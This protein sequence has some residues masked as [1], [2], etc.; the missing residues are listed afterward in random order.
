MYAGVAALTLAL[1]IGANV[2]IFTVLNGMLLR[3]LAFPDGDRIVEVR[4]H[5]PGLNMANIEGSP[6]LIL[7]YRDASRTLTRMAGYDQRRVN[8]TGSGAPERVRA[9]AVT[10]EIFDVLATRPALGRPFLESDAQEHSPPVA[11]LTHGLWQSR[12]GADPA[13]VGRT[14]QLDGKA[15][16]VIG[17][18]PRDFVFP[19]P[20]TRLLGSTAGHTGHRVRQLL[21]V[22][23]VAMALV[24]LVGSGLM[25]KSMARLCSID[26]GF[27]V[28]G[29]LTSSVSLGAQNDRR[30]PVQFYLPR[31]GRG[32]KHAR[33]H[34][35][36]CRERSSPRGEWIYGSKLR[37]SF[38]AEA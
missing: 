33:C 16:E 17:V 5:A 13:I 14:M 36:G 29:L 30:R 10:P 26:P 11:I 9:V 1:G 2:A 18:M 38:A 24:F 19:D 15:A 21:I 25:L 20:E 34:R 3:P 4:H 28:E 22:A 31:A 37:D 32:S 6:G 7:R 23:Q 12:F 35:G 27:R 8:L